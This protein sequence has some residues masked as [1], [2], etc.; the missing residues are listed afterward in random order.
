VRSSCDMG[1]LGSLVVRKTFIDM[2]DSDY[3]EGN[4]QGWIGAN[5]QVGGTL[6]RSSTA[7]F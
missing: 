5:N 6:M 2:S 1:A 4:R 7:D 3:T